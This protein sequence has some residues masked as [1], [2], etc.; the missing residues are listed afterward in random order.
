MGLPVMD[1]H[2]VDAREAAR[3][4]GI[5]VRT[6]W[7]LK[8]DGAIPYYQIGRRVLFALEDLRAWARQKRVTAAPDAERAD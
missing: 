8:K 1:P 6:L 5:S 3:F 2:L 7:Q 4:L